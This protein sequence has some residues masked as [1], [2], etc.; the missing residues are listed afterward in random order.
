MLVLPIL[1]LHRQQ[2]YQS[3]PSTIQPI[4]IRLARPSQL[5]PRSSRFLPQRPSVRKQSQS[6][7]IPITSQPSVDTS[8]LV[9]GSNEFFRPRRIRGS[10]GEAANIGQVYEKGQQGAEERW[11]FQRL[12]HG[13]SRR[14]SGR[15]SFHYISQANLGAFERVCHFLTE[16]PTTG[17][18]LRQ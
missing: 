10:G 4:G 17:S 7:A 8:I 16:I 11:F 9:A 14:A 6:I 5:D 15:V 3:R 1:F 2:R 12:G 13:P 18:Q